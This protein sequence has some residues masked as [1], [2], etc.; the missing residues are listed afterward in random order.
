MIKRP[1]SKSFK[2]K[3]RQDL[4]VVADLYSEPDDRDVCEPLIRALGD[5][6]KI[7]REAAIEMLINLDD[8]YSSHSILWTLLHGNT[9]ARKAAAR[10][11]T[12]IG[13]GDQSVNEY[14][15][16]AL[17]DPNKS[18]RFAVSEALIWNGMQGDESLLKV[19]EL[20]LFTQ[21]SEKRYVRNTAKRALKILEGVISGVM[22]L[23]LQ[24]I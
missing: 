13:K 19:A 10:V 9:H 6:E 22:E 5:P 21:K 7:V 16:L 11:L 4:M 15:T 3:I 12:E 24:E 17:H 18:V 1:L 14:L 8:M 2:A 20:L 23:K